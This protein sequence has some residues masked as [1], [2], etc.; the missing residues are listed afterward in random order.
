[1]YS[2]GVPD[3][4]PVDCIF[5]SVSYIDYVKGSSILT[6]TFSLAGFGKIVI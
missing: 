2:P 1:M 6:K 4:F 5:P 3:S